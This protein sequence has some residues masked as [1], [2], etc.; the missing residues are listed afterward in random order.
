[1]ADSTKQPKP[2]ASDPEAQKIR[3]DFDKYY[4]KQRAAHPGRVIRMHV[5]IDPLPSEQVAWTR[6]NTRPLTAAETGRSN[7]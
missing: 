6:G 7:G 3:A 2:Q 5:E 4:D 1:M